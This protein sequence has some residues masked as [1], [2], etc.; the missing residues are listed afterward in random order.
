MRTLRTLEAVIVASGEHS[1][2]TIARDLDLPVATVHRQVASLI[3]AGYLSRGKNG[4]CFVGPR[5]L[6]L[7]SHFDERTILAEIAKPVL[8]HIAK[9]MKTTVHL[10]TFEGDMVT[11]RVKT[12]GNSND[13]FTRIGLQLEAYCSGMGKVL[14]ANL[15]PDK[16]SLYLSFGP[17][18]P[19]TPNTIVDP[20]KLET[21]LRKI[22]EQG[23]ARDDEEMQQGLTCIAVPVRIGTQQVVAAL[24][25]SWQDSSERSMSENI[26]LS[27]LREAADEI[28]SQWI[29]WS[30]RM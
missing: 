23:F 13:L 15:P 10:G 2:L 3:A 16:Q 17:F 27:L 14:L 11:Y 4:R 25:A 26:V 12:G 30:A 22:R 9:R 28:E 5:L 1:V 29:A 24:S 19:L 18:I 21:E 8:D 6:S 7:S 20:E